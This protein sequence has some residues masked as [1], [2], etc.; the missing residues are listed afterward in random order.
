[1]TFYELSIIGTLAATFAVTCVY[2]FLYRLY[3]HSYMGLWAAFW[4][5]HFLSQ[6]F[7]RTPPYT[8][9]STGLAL[10]QCVLLLNYLLLIIG[11]NWFLGRK[12]QPVWYY[13]IIAVIIITDLAIFF[14]AP[15]MIKA[16]PSCALVSCVYLWHGWMYMKHLDSRGWGKHIVGIAFIGLGVHSLDMPFLLT[17]SW[18]AP[19]GF[20]ISGVLRFVITIGTLML[21]VEKNFRDLVAQERQY[22]LLAEHAGDT[23][24]LCSLRPARGVTY[25]SPSITKLTGYTVEDFT[26]QP[27]LLFSLAHP[28][29]TPLVENL[30]SNPV[31]ATSGPLVLRLI[32]RDQKVVWVEQTTVPIHNERGSCILFEG[33]LRDITARKELEQDV[34]RLD[35]LNTVGQMAANMAHEI[36]NPMTTVRGYLQ[37][38]SAKP[39]FA[40]YGDHFRMLISELDRA[41]LII[42]EYLSL[43]QNKSRALKPG[44][45]NDIIREI[46]PLLKADA[47]A[48]SKDVHCLLATIPEIYLDD[49]EI[50]QLILN[51]VRNGLEAMGPGG[52]LTVQTR[53]DAPGEVVL[54][55]RDEGGGIPPE[56]Q[57]QLGK[58]FVTTKEN[59]TGLGLAVVYRVANEHQAKIQV[60]TGPEGTTFN[61]SFHAK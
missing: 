38:F 21:Y 57:D 34:S 54:S 42:K 46:Y 15:F 10:L 1:M 59:G 9:S 24:Y 40:N 20:L 19:W 52:S 3:R 39:D 35:R 43:C 17:V 22:R 27:G 26:K 11:T 45:I 33:I 31:A 8:I 56:I 14:D 32:R 55:I 47:I 12:M 16:L 4:L 13:V 25:V 53:S 28:S 49:K 18:F 51:L 36:R 58:P 41:D 30:L 2:F 29:D 60:D 61:I 50:R 23:I 7:Y 44:Q 6:L 48:S 5:I 37:F